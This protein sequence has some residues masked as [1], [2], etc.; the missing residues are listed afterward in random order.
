MNQNT[1]DML[2]DGLSNLEG[3][4]FIKTAIRAIKAEK[5]FLDQAIESTKQAAKES[6][7]PEIIQGYRDLTKMRLQL[8]YVINNLTKSLAERK[9]I[10]SNLMSAVE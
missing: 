5:D 7:N 8:V 1:L 3:D 4:S 10:V 2:N 6:K 9:R